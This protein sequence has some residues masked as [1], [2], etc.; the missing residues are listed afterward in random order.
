MEYYKETPCIATFIF[1][2]NVMFFFLA[3]LFCKIREEEDRTGSAQREVG[4]I[5]KREGTEKGGRRVNGEKKCVHMHENAIM[6]PI[7]ALA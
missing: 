6:I 7:V 4:K 2:K 3:F 1:N 5:R